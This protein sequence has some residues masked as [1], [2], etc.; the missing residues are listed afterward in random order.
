MSRRWS[1]CLRCSSW[2]P[3]S[4]Y[5]PCFSWGIA[6]NGSRD[7]PQ[8]LSV[9]TALRTDK[10]KGTTTHKEMATH[11]GTAT[12]ITYRA[13]MVSLC[14]RFWSYSHYD[15]EHIQMYHCH[16]VYRSLFSTPRDK[17]T[18]TWRA[19]NVSSTSA[20]ECQANS[21]CSAPDV[22]REASWSLQPGH[23]TTTVLLHH[24]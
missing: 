5:W 18:G 20:A 1:S 12:D 23:C 4:P 13:L 14:V 10:H 11:K 19:A 16:C 2:A 22:H 9:T 3:W 21:A 7:G 8:P 6:L 17:P 24:A 15:Q